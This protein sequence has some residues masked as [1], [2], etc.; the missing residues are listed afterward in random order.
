MS[1]L[2]KFCTRSSLQ[3]KTTAFQLGLLALLLIILSLVSV[4]SIC[5]GAIS[6]SFSDIWD[7]LFHGNQAS[8]AYKIVSF[9]RLPRTFAAVFA[10]AALAVSGVM[11]QAVLNNPLAGPNIIG[12]NA[13]SGLMVMIVTT[14]FP[15]MVHLAPLAAFW[16]ALLASLLIYVIALGTG[17]SRVTI[18]LAGVAV[19]SFLSAGIDTLVT[20]F[21]DVAVGA[22]SFMVGGFSNVT[23]EGIRSALACIVAGLLMAL[24]LSHDMNV[25]ALGDETARSLG[26]KVGRYRFLLIIISSIL[27]GSA[28]S[29]AGLLGF[30]GLIVPHGARFLVGSDNRYLVPA[31]A[32]CGGIFTVGCD[33]LARILFAPYE[34][35][36]GIIMSFLGGPFFIY[37]LLRQKRSR[38]YD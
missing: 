14:L 32:L 22:S 20:L 2:Q 31:S 26:M 25:L 4:L 29:F 28:V 15:A 16:G 34:I 17:A 30:V 10:G 6:F 13:G 7:V 8:P 37:L 38:I 9:V 1:I 18:V 3:N 27:A 24:L 21:P 12:I 19:S 33:L 23:M 11:L 5:C 35:P 36:V